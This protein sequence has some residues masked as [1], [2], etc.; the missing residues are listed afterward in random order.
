MLTALTALL[1]WIGQLIGGAM[2]AIIALVLAVVMNMGA[3]WF[4][5]KLVLKMT[6]AKP[7]SPSEA[8]DLHRM[9]ERLAER[10]GIP[11]PALYI[12]EDPSPNAFATGRSPEKGVV[13]V[14]TGL[15]NLLNEREVEGVVAHEMAHIKS[16][17]R[18]SEILSNVVA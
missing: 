3:F 9:V 1:V 16:I 5:D 4:S 8:P 12:V 7:V 18:Y 14:N 17:K 10:A 2:G 11:K 13:A 15:L 6:K